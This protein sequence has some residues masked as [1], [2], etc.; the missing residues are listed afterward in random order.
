[1]ISPGRRGP[2]GPRARLGVGAVVLAG[3]LIRLLIVA[4]R[5]EAHRGALLAAT[6]LVPLV[7]MGL[8]VLALV[9][10]R[11]GRRGRL[12]PGPPAPL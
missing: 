9:S 3:G 7:G 12:P 5:P 1:M 10:G 4:A 11:R 8:I 6:A 2:N